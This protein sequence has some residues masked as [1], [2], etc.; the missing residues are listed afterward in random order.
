[1]SPGVG[2]RKRAAP[3]LRVSR[4]GRGLALPATRGLLSVGEAWESLQL[5]VSLEDETTLQQTLSINGGGLS[6]LQLKSDGGQFLLR[7]R[8]TLDASIGMNWLMV[9]FLF[10][11][12]SVGVY[13]GTKIKPLFQK[14]ATQFPWLICL[15]LSI[16]A[17]LILPT[18]IP[19]IVLFAV[20]SW[21]AILQWMDHRRNSKR[22]GF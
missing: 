4:E 5:T 17:L 11:A 3:L 18:T 15:S 14:L 21:L 22:Y 6:K 9:T 8:E 19:A 13:L 1:M 2:D 10:L 7:K 16:L 12:V 20:A